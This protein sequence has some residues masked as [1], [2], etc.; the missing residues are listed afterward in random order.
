[1]TVTNKRKAV[2]HVK[3]HKLV[4]LHYEDPQTIGAGC[5]FTNNCKK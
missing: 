3:L 1:M 5:L 4:K 2:P